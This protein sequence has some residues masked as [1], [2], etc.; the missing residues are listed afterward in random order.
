MLEP[1]DFRRAIKLTVPVFFG[2]ISIGIPFGL[3]IVNAGYPWWIAVAMSIFIYSGTA[4]YMA[5]GLF[6]AKAPLTTILVTQFFIGIRHIVYG[7]SLLKKFKGTGKLKPFLIFALSDETYALQSTCN[8][9]KN[10]DSGSFYGTIAFF[11]YL[12]WN[13]GTLIGA[14]LGTFIPF[15]FAGVEFALNA[16]F[17]VIII[18]QLRATKD[19]VPTI[20][21]FSTCVLSIVLAQ[22]G[23]MS[24]QHV[25]IVALALGIFALIFARGLFYKNKKEESK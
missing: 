5:V 23:Y 7:L 12:Y 14:L 4:Q 24:G 8:V 20:I 15:S 19:F 11:D 9:P 21:G 6:V 16:L 3:M 2:Y 10:A 18:N 13:L 25:L 17:V 1:Y 22:K